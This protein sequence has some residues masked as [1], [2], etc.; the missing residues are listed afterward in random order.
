METRVVYRADYEIEGWTGSWTADEL[1]QLV[2][3]TSNGQLSENEVRRLFGKAFNEER[4][5]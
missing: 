3:R 4:N 2:C 5:D 1:I